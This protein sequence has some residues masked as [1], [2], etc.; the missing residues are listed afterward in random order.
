MLRRNGGSD[1]LARLL[2]IVTGR[3][4]IH[5]RVD[6][7][8]HA[9]RAD[10]RRELEASQASA[11]PE[12]IW[13]DGNARQPWLIVPW[14]D[15]LRQALVAVDDAAI[16]AAAWAKRSGVLVV[17]V[18]GRD[19]PTAVQPDALPG[20]R[21][22]WL[23]AAEAVAADGWAV[24]SLPEA[25]ANAADA[26]GQVLKN[27]PVELA[28][29]PHDF[30]V[31]TARLVTGRADLNIEGLSDAGVL[32][33]SGPGRWQLAPELRARLLPLMSP[34]AVAAARR[35]WHTTL[36]AGWPPEAGR[37]A[38]VTGTVAECAQLWH[39]WWLA[40]RCSDWASLVNSWNRWARRHGEQLRVRFWHHAMLG[41][42]PDHGDAHVTRGKLA[43]GIARCEE[44]LGRHPSA[45]HWV[46]RALALLPTDHPSRLTTY[47]QLGSSHFAE[48][49]LPQAIAAAEAGIA[50]GEGAGF[51]D[52]D[53]SALR[54]DLAFYLVLAGRA[55][56]AEAP[57]RAAI[58]GKRS[59][60][61]HY[62][63][64]HELNVLTM[65]LIALDRSVEG[66]L[67]AEEALA[68]AIREQHVDVTPYAHHS[69]ALALFEC[70]RV[71]DAY[72]AVVAAISSC[73]PQIH[74]ELLPLVELTQRRI[75]LRARVDRDTLENAVAAAAR[76]IE[77]ASLSSVYA[78]LLLAEV[79]ATDQQRRAD[80]L[81]LLQRLAEQGAE[82]HV[83]AMLRAATA[84]LATSD[85]GGSTP[86]DEHSLAQIARLMEHFGAPN[87]G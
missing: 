76:G 47:L 16:G 56:E 11:R 37:T 21:I 72:Q 70:G 87:A 14:P 27:L 31:A 25:G 4:G 75:E 5:L 58:A 64:A 78:G 48:N 51:T 46:E 28:A 41:T 26:D 65:L 62:S 29:I 74:A 73:A 23:P 34:E 19:V 68:E 36:L 2:Q 69:L 17:I 83:Q 9:W 12:T 35:A 38:T 39:D 8:S 60:A 44:D 33:R 1:S 43:L 22:L 30:S 79:L 50:F 10:L 54:S 63:V 86:L 40:G 52:I 6:N 57:L 49:D 32:E 3:K 7:T 67:S 55:S 82:G 53:L 77:D 85:A 80:A 71:A 61:G 81:T 20:A 66:V 24:M 18:G 42:A 13:L 59:R 45:R 15:D 84:R